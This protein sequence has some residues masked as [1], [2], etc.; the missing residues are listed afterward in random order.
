MTAPNAELAYTVLDLALAHPDHL[1]MD[2]WAYSRDDRPVQLADLTDQDCGTTAC[3]AG[4]TAAHA[5][6]RVRSTGFAYR[7]GEP[8]RQV[9]WVAAR[10]LGITNDEAFEL[11]YVSDEDL[12]DAVEAIFGPRPAVT[13]P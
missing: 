10:L 9:T 1:D 7:D 13:A 8:G 5:G 6:W 12:P 11:F 3:Y 4:W 2:E